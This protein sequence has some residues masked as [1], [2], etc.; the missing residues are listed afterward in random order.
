[1]RR[2][3][4]DN[5]IFQAFAGD[6]ELDT[7]RLLRRDL[8]GDGTRFVYHYS[9]AAVCQIKRNRLIRLIAAS[10]AILVPVFNDLA[11]FY[12][13]GEAFAQTENA[14]ADS[15]GK[16]LEKKIPLLRPIHVAQSAPPAL[17]QHPVTGLK[18]QIPSP[19]LQRHAS[20]NAPG[21]Q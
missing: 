15:K 17:S 9:I 4:V 2:R 3:T 10:A 21:R 7:V 6:T 19:A 1:M 8:E 5:K 11:V 20:G 14:F 12:E 13:G 18:P 16:L